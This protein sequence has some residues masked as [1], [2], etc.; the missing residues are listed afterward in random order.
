MNVHELPMILFTVLSQM[1]VG[2][3]VVLGFLQVLTAGKSSAKVVDRL[4][5]PALLA[6]GPTLVLG[7]I[8]STFHMNDITNTLN[9]L[10]HWNS[11]WLSREIIFGVGFAGLGFFYVIAQWRGWFSARVRQLL[12]VLTA[13]MG[14]AL[15]W[16]QAMIYYSL[17][18]VPGW[19]HWTTP[20]RF[21]ATTIMLGAL[22][23]GVA[24]AASLSKHR[25]TAAENTDERLTPAGMH[26][27]VQAVGGGR[28]GSTLATLTRQTTL[29]TEE[30]IEADRLVRT[31]LRF[32]TLAAAVTALVLL[33]TLP[34]Y[35]GYLNSRP[36][37]AAQASAE[38]YQGG[39]FV[40][41]LV[42]LAVG[43]IVIS[44]IAN[45]A[46]A[47]PS[48]TPAKLTMIVF[49]SLAVTFI[50]ELMGRS[51]FYDTIVRIGV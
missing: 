20:V 43:A 32:L 37:P 9:V 14:L 7:L 17:V 5:N 18:T 2:A 8:A 10:R 47:M 25:P 42:L 39:F 44:L 40:A 19:N 41:Y 48:V 1:S 30:T 35:L 33:V 27:D 11:S 12:A 50:A 13:V 21:F 46:I 24:M 3:F 36:E 16:S 4:S 49:A 26:G 28:A 23:V 15:V 6:I 34:L 51:L 29:T 38:V 45:R 22:A 31:A